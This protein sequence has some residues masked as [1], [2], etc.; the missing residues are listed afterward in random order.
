ML[1]IYNTLTGN[2]EPLKPLDDNH[3]RIYVCGM[4]VYDYCHLG[5]ARVMVGF[6]TVVRYL[7]YRGYKVTYVRNITDIDDKIITRANELGE[8]ISTLTNR[9]IRFMNED[10]DALAV[11]KPDHEPRA[12]EYIP[13]IIAMITKL[14]ESGYAYPAANGDVY[15]RVRKFK[16]YGN[17]S[18]TRLD[19]LVAGAR[20]EP[21]EMKDD[22]VDFVLWKGSKPDEPSW[23]SPW[24][25]GRPGWH[26]EC[27]AMS[28]CLLGSHFDIHGGG[29]DLIFPHHENEIAQS[30]AATDE[31]F[32]NTWMHNGYLEINAEKMSKSL[33]NF[34]TIRE[35]LATDP[36]PKKVGEILRFMFLMS[37]YRS[38]LNYRDDS[39][40][41]AKAALTRIYTAIN[42]AEQLGVQPAD[43]LDES[44]VNRFC[45]AMD[46]DFN[47][48]D[49]LAVLFDCVR[50][51]NRAFQSQTEETVSCLYGT[52]LE[53]T[54]A[55]GIASLDATHFLGVEQAVADDGIKEL[56]LQREQARRDKQWAVA[57]QIRQQ[58]TDLGVEVEDRPDGTSTWRKV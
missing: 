23:E 17:L 14:V 54:G 32:V 12:T 57:D 36:D 28:T 37:H 19:E 7:R 40:D 2:K 25:A 13:Q 11:I 15:Y 50:E 44:L 38:P 1:N 51:L 5:H 20:V 39:L 6:D 42:K 46:D 43:Q 22:P 10:L 18:G 35:I 56:I 53:L 47:T 33:H 21:D 31:T 3:V 58:L 30:E 29:M 16:K 26:I 27:S 8:S 52:L 45:S 49:G 9:Y 24:G 48:A 34:L 55:L 41:N 4:T